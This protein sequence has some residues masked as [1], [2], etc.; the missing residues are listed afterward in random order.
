MVRAPRSFIKKPNLILDEREI[1]MWSNT[2]LANKIVQLI[3]GMVVNAQTYMP[4]L[5][6][7]AA[8]QK[9]ELQSMK[10]CLREAGG[11]E[12]IRNSPLLL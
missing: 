10:A 7:V 8:E 9:V 2:G 3:L 6:G 11:I 1:V 5:I 4:V 12:E